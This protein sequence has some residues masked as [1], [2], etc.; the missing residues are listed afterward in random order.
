MKNIILTGTL[1]VSVFLLAGCSDSNQK[2][3]QQQQSANLDLQSKCAEMAS[4]YFINKGYKNTDGFDYQNHFNPK[5]DKC[6]ILIT[7]N[8]TD[9]SL[10]ID[11]YDALEG[12]HYASFYGHSLCID[13]V[14]NNKNKCTM[15]GGSVWLDGNDTKNPADVMVG[16]RGLK[17]GGGTGDENTQK[18]FMDSIQTF[19]ND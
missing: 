7:S 8:T 14:N 10:F 19:M 2:Q 15:D 11:L 18:Q 4:K 13:Y 9:N 1:L 6:F 3:P 17:N 5:L 12:K 16:F